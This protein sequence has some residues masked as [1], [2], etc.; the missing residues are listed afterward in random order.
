[1]KSDT[2][3]I[4]NHPC[5]ELCGN[6]EK[7]GIEF[8]R[9]TPLDY[10]V[11]LS[12]FLTKYTQKPTYQYPIW[13]NLKPDNEFVVEQEFA[14]LWFDELLPAEEL[15]LFFDLHDS[16]DAVLLRNGKG[17]KKTLENSYTFTFYISNQS[18]SFYFAYNNDHDQLSAGGE[19]I[20]WLKTYLDK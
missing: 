4:R 8:K 12:G 13:E 6:L 20:A 17:L 5:H 11:F 18:N 15:I 14:W 19:A 1:M 2:L 3:Y 7:L 9:L 10:E 16:P